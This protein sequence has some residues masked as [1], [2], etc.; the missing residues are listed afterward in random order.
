M[1][2]IVINKDSKKT[3]IKIID[4]WKGKLT[5]DLLCKRVTRELD[6]DEVVTRHTLLRYDEIKIAFKNKKDILKDS[7]AIKLELGDKA[8]EKAY[9][10]ILNL[11]T[12]NSRL[13]SENSALREQFVRWQYNLYHIKG[14][15]IKK[16][17]DNVNH[18]L[19]PINR[20]K[21]N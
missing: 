11:Q 1:P 16:I 19:P 8:L 2:K 4:T 10:R 20:K 14:L 6:L 9:E 15:E 12:E 3:I 21:R 17:M 5:W 18:D 7:P 13:Q